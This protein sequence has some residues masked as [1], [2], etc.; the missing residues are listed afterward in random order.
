MILLSGE[1][2]GRQAAALREE[3]RRP[4]VS[5]R[6]M[7]TAALV[8][9]GFCRGRA[10]SGGDVWVRLDG[11]PRGILAVVGRGLGTVYVQRY[12]DRA[13]LAPMAKTTLGASSAPSRVGSGPEG[14]SS[15]T[16]LVLSAAAGVSVAG[17]YYIQP[18][19]S[20][21][22]GRFGVGVGQAG[23]LFA[24][25]QVGYILG[26]AFIVPLGDLR[27]QRNVLAVLLAVSA[28]ASACVGLAES[29]YVLA[30]ALVVVGVAASATMLALPLAA[31]LAAPER[32]GSAT[33]TVMSGLLLG[34]LLSQ[35]VSGA[36]A[37]LW[38][39]HSVFFLAAAVEAVL[40]LVVWRMVPQ[41]AAAFVG[42]YR[43]LLLS[44]A[45][46]VRRSGKLRGRMLLGFLS[47]F[48]FSLA[49]TSLAFL[50]AGN[51]GSRYSF[52]TAT[53][54]LFGLAGAAGVL[55][56][57]IVGKWADRGHARRASTFSWCLLAASWAALATGSFSI[58]PLVAGLVVFNLAA[59]AVQLIN[60][61][62]IYE[63][64][65]HS[66]SR[67]ITAYMVSFFFGGVAGSFTSGYVYQAGGW[68]AVCAT[69]FGVGLVGLAAWAVL[70]RRW[71]GE[72]P[73]A[74]E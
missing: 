68:P 25:A 5:E 30:L 28:A 35:T 58:V 59:E 33:G 69:G 46:I 48:G 24:G 34:V 10:G 42:T 13:K 2:A 55:G 43:Q 62:S 74:D 3:R 1:I 14:L 9:G 7:E 12:I 8:V 72:E 4:A 66:R 20:L 41:T 57:P 27:S 65:P 31:S 23:L 18:L 56:A 71:A 6:A 54:G 70:A 39:W 16:L 26:L 53:I 17:L 15:A 22:A 32:R 51:G 50:L 52:S 29:F 47:M 21:V 38:G 44:V 64:F 11:G 60:Q 37:Q 19:L 61:H 73:A 40:A 36:M 67:A 63:T 49:W 45:G